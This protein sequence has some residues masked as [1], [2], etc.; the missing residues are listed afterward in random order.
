MVRGQ[1]LF[2]CSALREMENSGHRFPHHLL[3]CHLPKFVL[4]SIN[5][6]WADISNIPLLDQD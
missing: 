5:L 4:C 3:L 1:E 2:G 6:T